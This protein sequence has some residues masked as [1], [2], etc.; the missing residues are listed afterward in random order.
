MNCR[1]NK[2]QHYTVKGRHSDQFT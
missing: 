2:P 1:L